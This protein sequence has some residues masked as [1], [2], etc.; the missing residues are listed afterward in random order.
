MSRVDEALAKLK[1]CKTR[2]QGLKN[3]LEHEEQKRKELE[4]EYRRESVNRVLDYIAT[5]YRQG[6][7]CNLDIMF[8]HCMNK[9]NGNIDGVEI[10][11]DEHNKGKEFEI[12]KIIEPEC[13]PYGYDDVDVDDFLE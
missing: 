6:R 10:T 4:W 1:E 12:K 5:E 9:L 11:L 8:T 3:S 2:V 13:I 7:L